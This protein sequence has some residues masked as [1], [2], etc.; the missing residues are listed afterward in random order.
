MVRRKRGVAARR[1]IEIA[2]QKHNLEQ[3]HIISNEMII[4]LCIVMGAFLKGLIIGYLSRRR[5]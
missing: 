3:N 5:F 1:K 2:L 4:G